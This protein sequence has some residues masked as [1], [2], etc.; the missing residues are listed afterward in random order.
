V[1]YELARGTFGGDVWRAYYRPIDSV[2]PNVILKLGNGNLPGRNLWVTEFRDWRIP[3][4]DKEHLDPDI[5]PMSTMVANAGAEWQIRPNLVGAVR[6]TRNQLRNTI[7]D[8]GT[9]IDG[10]EVYIYGNP[11]KGLAKMSSPNSPLVQPFELPLAK[12]QYDA[13]EFS[14]TRRLSNRWFA[15][16]SYVWSRLWGNYAGLQNSDEVNPAGT[17]RVS[18]TSQQVSG[19]AYRPG[20]SAS[21]AYDL[22]YYALDSRGNIGNYGR[23]ASDR[24]HVFKLYGSYTLPWKKMHSTEL[25]GFFYAASGTPVSTYVADVQNVPL[26]V[27]GRGDMGRT[28]ILNYTNLLVAH[29]MRVREGKTIR[30]EF[31][32]DNVFNQKTSR[33][34]YS[35]YNRYRTVSSGMNL[36]NIDYRKGYDYKAM[37]AASPDAAKPTG[38]LDPRFGMADSFNTGF[39]GRLGVKYIF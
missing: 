18:V 36:F 33:L 5:K 13:V 22:D 27:N 14:F 28:P 12:R 17:G 34:T 23:L 24:P 6:Y 9:V 35:F 30:V 4:F 2:D 38:A 8:I 3:A 39:V 21:R 31:N 7:E 29:E 20:T 26:F 37:V 11:G 16:G 10:S 1:K 32:A 19:T 15:S 25:G